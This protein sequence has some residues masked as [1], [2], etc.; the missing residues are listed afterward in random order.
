MYSRSLLKRLHIVQ[1]LQESLFH[2]FGWDDYNVFVFG[3]FLTEKYQ[4]GVSD[5]DIAVYVK[6]V[7][8][9]IEIAD[10][11]LDFF[12]H[13]HIRVDIF[14]IDT[15]TVAP[16][17]YAPLHSKIR[18]TSYYPPELS[19]FYSACKQSYEECLYAEVG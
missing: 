3:S 10:F 15:Q 6:N 11:I 2:E 17:Y 4:A 14:Y 1:T 12:K 19:L 7:T 5:I 16:I 9:Y 18:L 13:Y 8:R